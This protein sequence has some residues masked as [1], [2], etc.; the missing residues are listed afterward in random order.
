MS[1]SD[2][3]SS[4]FISTFYDDIEDSSWKVEKIRKSFACTMKEY[5]TMYEIVETTMRDVDVL[6]KSLTFHAIKTRLHTILSNINTRF[7]QNSSN[8]FVTW[9]IKIL[10]K[11]TH[12]INNNAIK[13]KRKRRKFNENVQ[14]NSKQ[15]KFESESTSN[16]RK[17]TRETITQDLISC[18]VFENK[19]M[20]AQQSFNKELIVFFCDT[21][22]L[23][24]QKK[25]LKKIIVEN[26]D[27]DKWK[28]ILQEDDVITRIYDKIM[29][30]SSDDSL[31]IR[32]DR[33]LRATLN[34]MHFRDMTRFTFTMMSSTQSESRRA[35]SISLRRDC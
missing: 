25:S 17:F 23:M 14:S 9:R 26:L 22:E 34:E 18:I 2:V 32:N 13:H 4:S 31:K 5:F 10:T 21:I 15:K 24:S 6:E 16:R 30:I 3:R 20:L 7:E 29:Y 28:S 11:L 12:K 27:F 35:C 33:N 8:I 19:I 1:H